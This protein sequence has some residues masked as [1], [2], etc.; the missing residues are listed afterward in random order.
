MEICCSIQ[1]A[2]SDPQLVLHDTVDGSEIWR[3]PVEVASLSHYLRQVLCPIP[4]AD[5]RI[6]EAST[7]ASSYLNKD[8]SFLRVL[9]N[10]HDETNIKSPCQ[11]IHFR[12]LFLAGIVSGSGDYPRAI[13]LIYGFPMTGYVGPGVLPANPTETK[14]VFGRP[15]ASTSASCLGGF[16][17][18]S[19]ARRRPFFLFWVK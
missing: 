4:G 9:S 5:H 7:I 18:W 1:R 17:L 12:G 16:G 14:K 11:P 10:P 6:S 8:H 13:G 19:S 15:C 3:S 2:R